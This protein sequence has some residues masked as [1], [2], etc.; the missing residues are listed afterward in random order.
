MNRD[1]LVLNKGLM[2]LH[3]VSWKRALTLLVQDKC[4][5]VDEDFVQYD[6]E[7]WIAYSSEI[8]S[9]NKFCFIR[10]TK[11]EIAIPHVVVLT[12]YNRLPRNQVKYS[13]ETLF[14]RDKYRCAYCGKKFKSSE[15]TI[16]HINPK[17]AGGPKSWKNTITACKPCNNIK[18]NRT[19]AQA[20]MYLKF[21]PT[22]P[23]WFQQIK[24]LV[25][26]PNIKKEWLQFLSSFIVKK[27]EE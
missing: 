20:Q 14:Q 26:R 9:R 17:S 11:Y 18:A 2:P 10:T 19:P 15:L 27:E 12:A 7:L 24:T 16:D 21:E 1:V 25:E 5:A 22:E 13:R 4:R 8:E 23:S 3:I 6:C